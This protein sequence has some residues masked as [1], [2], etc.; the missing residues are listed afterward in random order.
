MCNL[1][2]SD[3]LTTVGRINEV[4]PEIPV[5]FSDISRSIQETV[6]TFTRKGKINR[7]T[8]DIQAEVPIKINDDLV[9]KP[10]LVDHSAYNSFMFLIEADGKKVLYTGDYRNHGYKGKLFKPMLKK[11]RKDRHTNHRTARPYQ[12]QM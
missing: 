11:I 1:F 2:T 7:E 3:T 12:D 6:F 10:L 4:L 9:F 8:I 5:Y